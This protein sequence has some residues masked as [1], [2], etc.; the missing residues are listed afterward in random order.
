MKGVAVPKT[1]TIEAATTEAV[2]SVIRQCHE[3]ARVNDWP[4]KRIVAIEDALGLSTLELAAVLNTPEQSLDGEGIRM[5]ALG[6]LLTLLEMHIEH[7]RTGK[8]H[9]TI[10]PFEAIAAVKA[11]KARAAVA[12]AEATKSLLLGLRKGKRRIAL[13]TR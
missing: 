11:E 3:E 2:I 8:A 1:P 13:K 9:A 10:F 5:G 4:R 6:M 7:A 12:Q